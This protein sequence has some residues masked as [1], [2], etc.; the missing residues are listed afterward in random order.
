M[1]RGCLALR[2]SWGW[3]AIPAA[4]WLYVPAGGVKELNKYRY[5]HVLYIEPLEFGIFPSYK[6]TLLLLLLRVPPNMFC[7]LWSCWLFVIYARYI[8][9][10]PGCR[11]QHPSLS[12][13]MTPWQ[14]RRWVWLWS[15]APTAYLSVG[16]PSSHPPQGH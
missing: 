14:S 5:T 2:H 8:E 3:R 11:S 1:L 16:C 6:T 4:W 7:S 9:A 13:P 10:Y 15:K 12:R